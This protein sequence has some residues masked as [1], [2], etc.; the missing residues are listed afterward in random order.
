MLQECPE[1][2]VTNVVG[3]AGVNYLFGVALK[4]AG[5]IALKSALR[6]VK[7]TGVRWALE[8]ALK[9]YH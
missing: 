6:C 5:R 4:G 1:M 8:C 2:D 9:L 7:W 3:I